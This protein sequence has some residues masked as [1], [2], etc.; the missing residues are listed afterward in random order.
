MSV[1]LAWAVLL[2]AVAACGG[3]DATD[4]TIPSGASLALTVSGLLPLDAPSG[5]YEAW[6]HDR[7]GVATSLGTIDVRQGS[8][9]TLSN[10]IA[11]ARAVSLTWEPRGDRDPA[12][13]PHRLL[14]G[15]F[16]GARAELALAGAVTQGILPLR[17]RPGQFTMFS[18][19]DNDVHG[20]PSFEE[21]GVWLFNMEPRATQQGDMW[22]RLTQLQPGWVYEGWMVRDIEAPGAIWLSYGKFTPDATGAVNAR[23]NTGWG[24]FSGALDFAT[25][26]EEEFP[27]DDWISNPLSLPF[28]AGLTLPLNLRELN[29]Q[30]GFRWTHV[31]TLE[32]AS[33]RGEPVGSERPF[34]IR[35]YRDAF[36]A[37]GP[38][39]ART[40]TFRADGVPSGQVARK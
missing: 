26:G 37:G 34:T 25:A 21:S 32:P 33:D 6:V 7:Q 22:V 35:P 23:D 17:D 36:G 13:S 28:P 38:G 11:D 29:A 16:R 4:A 1:R 18:P 10:P 27:G 31:I 39:A 24:P 2:F 20:Y 8:T 12:P 19:S 15:D 3:S 40:I 5:T 9:F 14:N 30:G